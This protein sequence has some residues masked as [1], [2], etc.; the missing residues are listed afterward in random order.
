MKKSIILRCIFIC[1]AITFVVLG[2]ELNAKHSIN[3]V[4]IKTNSTPIT[5]KVVILDAGHRPSR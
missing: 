4:V 2:F 1:I 5:N 3:E